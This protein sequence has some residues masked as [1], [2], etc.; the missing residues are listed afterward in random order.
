MTDPW[1]SRWCEIF[2]LSIKTTR[3]YLTVRNVVLILLAILNMHELVEPFESYV[4]L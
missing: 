3:Q 4:T 1:K 2:I